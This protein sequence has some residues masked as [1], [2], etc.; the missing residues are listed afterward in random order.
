MRG[1]SAICRPREPAAL[2]RCFR[3]TRSP[4]RRRLAVLLAVAALPLPGCGVEVAVLGAAASAASSGSAVYRRGKLDASWM[5]SFERVISGAELAASE[6][7]LELLSSAGDSAAGTW[8]VAA[9]NAVGEKVIVRVNR[10]ASSLVEFQIDIG[11]F[12]RESTA[13]L[14]LKRMAVAIGLEAEQ[15]GVL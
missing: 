7:G 2:H 12:G 8:T 10:K 1:P 6:L 4:I 9:R 15:N 5:A 13:Q 3:A 14:M 11:W